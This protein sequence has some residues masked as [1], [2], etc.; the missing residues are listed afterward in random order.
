MYYNYA[1]YMKAYRNNFNVANFCE[2]L[3]AK[4]YLDKYTKLIDSM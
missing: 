4:I 2:M 1:L 3:K